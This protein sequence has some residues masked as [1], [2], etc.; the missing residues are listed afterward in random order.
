MREWSAE[1]SFLL[2]TVA[3]N[4]KRSHRS[5]PTSWQIIDAQE[6]NLKS[7]LK[8]HPWYCQPYTLRRGPRLPRQQH[9]TTMRSWRTAQPPPFTVQQAPKWTTDI[10]AAGKLAGEGSAAYRSA[11]ND[12]HPMYQAVI[13]MKKTTGSW[14]HWQGV[15]R[16][17][18]SVPCVPRRNQKRWLCKELHQLELK[19]LN[20]GYQTHCRLKY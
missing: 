14:T 15:Y 3:K 12:Y 7:L 13:A 8:H 19:K 20:H 1:L 6:T 16:G 4:V 18:H 2:I 10:R 9:T 17:R 5:C 11:K